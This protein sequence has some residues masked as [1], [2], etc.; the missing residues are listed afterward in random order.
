L[1]VG[2]K[3]IFKDQTISSPEGITRP[4]NNV[5]MATLKVPVVWIASLFMLI[6]VGAEVSIG[7]WSYS[8]LT[9]ERH[10]PILL[11]G[12]IVTG[13]W[14]GL[15]L[16]RLTLARVTLRIGSERLIQ[17]CLVGV[18]IGALLVWL[19][20][21]YAASA[22]GLVLIGFSFGPIYPTTIAFISNRVSNRILPSAIG[23]L[24]S[25]GSV[26]AAVLPWFVGIL[27][28]HVGL[29]SLM[30]NVIILTAAMVCLWQALMKR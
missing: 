26:G 25:L 19:L 29:W 21:M 24:A 7:S 22:L 11:A 23:F 5:L 17:G 2:F 15:T 30:P 12:W 6:Y 3:L 18:V 1:L 16:G 4:K 28:E 9:E 13:Y 27:A 14:I 10:A 8:F 20:P